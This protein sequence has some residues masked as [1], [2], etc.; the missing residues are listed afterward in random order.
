MPDYDALRIRL[1]RVTPDSDVY[2]VWASATTGEVTGSF[3]VPVSHLELENLVL[4]MNRPRTVSRGPGSTELQAVRRFGSD[5]FS[6]LFAGAVRDLY[7]DGYSAAR[8]SRKGL[9]ITLS[10]TDTPELMDLP[11]E[12]LYEKPDFISISTWTP[13]VRYLELPHSLPP[14]EVTPP[15]RVLGLVSSPSDLPPLDVKKEKSKLEQA[16]ADARARGAADIQWVEKATLS[17]LGR[18]LRRADFHV[19]HYIGHSGY[20]PNL[21]TGVLCLENEEGKS[22]P[23]SG[24]NLAVMLANE[25]TLRLAVLN[26][27]EGARSST[28]DPFAGVATSLVERDIPA[29]VAMQFEITDQAAITFADEFYAAIADGLPID[30]A[31]AEARRMI[32]AGG[33][34]TEWAT[35][36]L[37]MRVPDGRIFDVPQPAEPLEREPE[38]PRPVPPEEP[39]PPP[40]PPEEP[41]REEPPKQPVEKTEPLPVL[42]TALVIMIGLVFVVGL[43]YPWDDLGR[44]WVDRHFGRAGSTANVLSALAPIAL[45]AGTFSAVLLAHLYPRARLLAG[46]LLVG[47]G[48]AGAAKYTALVANQLAKEGTRTD[49]VVVLGLVAISSCV[50][51]VLGTKLAARRQ[52]QYASGATRVVAGGLALVGASLVVVGC[53]VDY[54]SATSKSILGDDGWFALDPLAAVLVALGAIFVGGGTG[55]AGA[56]ALIAV[57]AVGLALWPRFIGVPILL[58]GASGSAAP[59]GFIGLLGSS[60]L[61]AAGLVLAWPRQTEPL[62]TAAPDEPHAAVST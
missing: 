38:K 1:E 59:G 11:W 15:L 9:R 32:Y 58:G 37:F 31:L 27:C 61:V 55:R 3:V 43:V 29:V 33:N 53:Y 4:R 28:T 19:F 10:L 39:P 30:S 44:S 41:R 7:R 57:G 45:I 14:I 62:P 36:V 2:R 12:Y 47:L 5:L 13:V 20:D 52:E 25:P 35:P 8:L 24:E 6:A 23:V 34:E 16:L 50:L 40:P 48:V 46:G 51:A 18:A 26:S 56:G 49:S 17:E 22:R 42:W 21:E 60:C 54:N